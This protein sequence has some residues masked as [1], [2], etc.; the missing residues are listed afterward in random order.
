MINNI[1]QEYQDERDL[2]IQPKATHMFQEQAKD[3]QNSKSTL[4]ENGLLEVE[5]GWEVMERQTG[6]V[7]N[8]PESAMKMGTDHTETER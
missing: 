6:R 8:T 4:R 5:E 3:D 7:S 2:R 1:T